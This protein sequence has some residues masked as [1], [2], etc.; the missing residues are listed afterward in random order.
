MCSQQEEK[1]SCIN[2]VSQL[3]YFLA[4]SWNQSTSLCVVFQVV[5]PSIKVT[6][7]MSRL[8]M[9]DMVNADTFY[10]GDTHAEPLSADSGIDC[11]K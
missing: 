8:K 7:S 6:T 11:L 9:L 3:K 2:L 1:L 10:N 5:V 4:T